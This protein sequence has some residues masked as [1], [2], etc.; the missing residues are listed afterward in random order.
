MSEW[1]LYGESRKE[2]FEKDLEPE[3]LRTDLVRYQKALGNEFGIHEML[4]LKDIKAKALIAEAVND[5]PEFLI[6]QLG[7]AR[8]SPNFPSLI[9][10]IEEIARVLED[11]TEEGGTRNG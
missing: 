11:I 10:T 1:S 6:D 3:A 4:L 2:S 7:K 8:N 9:R 5:A